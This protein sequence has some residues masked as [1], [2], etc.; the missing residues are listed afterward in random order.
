VAAGAPQMVQEAAP[1]PRNASKKKA[2]RKRR[3]T[4][5]R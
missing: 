4:G 1:V 5:G 3:P 2:K